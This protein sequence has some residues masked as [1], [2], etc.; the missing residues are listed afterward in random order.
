MLA[1]NKVNSFWHAHSQMKKK[2]YY[3]DDY[4]NLVTNMLKFDPNQRYDFNSIA[5]HPW[6]TQGET[7]SQHEVY[8]DMKKRHNVN[9]E[10]HEKQLRDE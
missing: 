5:A 2:E 7:A 6:I 9:V 8:E 3:S 10:M 1:K 4:K